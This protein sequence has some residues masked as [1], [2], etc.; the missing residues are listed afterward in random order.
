MSIGLSSAA[1]VETA[2]ETNVRELAAAFECAP[3]I[4]FHRDGIVTPRDV[5]GTD[6]VHIARLREESIDGAEIG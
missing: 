4:V 1:A 3:G 2:R 6:T 5:E